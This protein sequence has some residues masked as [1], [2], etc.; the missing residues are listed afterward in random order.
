MLIRVKE[1][2]EFWGFVLEFWL[3]T[4]YGATAD[5]E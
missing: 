2:D 3:M 4:P 5:K 1:L